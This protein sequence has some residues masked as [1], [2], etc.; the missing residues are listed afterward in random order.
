MGDMENHLSHM[1]GFAPEG[2]SLALKDVTDSM[3]QGQGMV[4]AKQGALAYLR[5]SREMGWGRLW[6]RGKEQLNLGG[7]VGF[8]C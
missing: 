1:T 5:Q 8:R 6:A 2:P 4:G 7:K 3:E